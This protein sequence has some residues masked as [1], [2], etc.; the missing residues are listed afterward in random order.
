MYSIQ[1][2]VQ[3]LVP[4]LHSGSLQQLAYN[5]CQHSQ[6]KSPPPKKSCQGQTSSV[7]EFTNTLMSIQTDFKLADGI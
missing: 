2:Y 3:V 7:L 4:I 5:L 1:V 6:G